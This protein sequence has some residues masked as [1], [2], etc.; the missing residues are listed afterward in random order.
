M[1]C[2]ILQITNKDE[3]N[4]NKP[5]LNS[6]LANSNLSAITT[7]TKFELTPCFCEDDLILAYY[8]NI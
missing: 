7:E 6:D 2:S 5:S 8:Q 4:K 3:Q 1:D